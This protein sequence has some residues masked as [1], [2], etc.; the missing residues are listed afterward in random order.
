LNGSIMSENDLLAL[1][2]KTEEM[3]ARPVYM[4]DESDSS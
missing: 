4:D 1:A 2:A 3:N